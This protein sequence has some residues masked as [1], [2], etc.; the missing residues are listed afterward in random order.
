MNLD[1][2]LSAPLRFRFCPG[3]QVHMLQLTLVEGSLL[4][5]ALR[6]LPQSLPVQEYERGYLAG[7]A[8][9]QA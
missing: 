6:L 9:R 2:T 8:R 3:A 7:A 1:D 4:R 5:W